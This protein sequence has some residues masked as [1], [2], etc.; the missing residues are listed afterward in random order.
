MFS[1]VFEIITGFVNED[2]SILSALFFMKIFIIASGFL[3]FRTNSS[4][5]EKSK[6]YIEDQKNNYESNKP[7]LNENKKFS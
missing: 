7:T 1:L 2:E 6:N 4:I 5:L 3:S